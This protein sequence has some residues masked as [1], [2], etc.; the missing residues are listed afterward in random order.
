M[1]RI[2]GTAHRFCD[3]LTRR[4]F[5]QIGALGM[6]GLALPELLRAESASR[7]G[8]SQKSVIMV[9]LPGGPPHQDLFDLKLDA[10]SEI[11]GEMKPIATRVPGIQVCEVLPR[12]AACMD[13]VAVIRSIVGSDGGHDDFQCMTGRSMRKPPGGWPQLGAVVSKLAGPT[14]QDTPAFVG[15]ENRM[16]H[17]PYNSSTPGFLG[18]A[19]RSFLPNGEAKDD[20]VLTS[21]TADRLSNRRGLLDRLD[22]FRRDADASGAMDGLDAF[23]KQAYGIL[24]SSRLVEALDYR[25]EDP[26]V[27]ERYGKG[28]PKIRGDAAPRIN[29]QF[30]MARRLIEAGVRVV[31]VAYGFW[32]YHGNNFGL[33]RE[34]APMLDQAL[35]ALVEDLH[36]RGLDQDVS[37]VV[38]GEFGRTPQINK[39][40]GR[41]HWPRVSCAL[42]AGGG[43]RT[44]QVIGATDRMGGEA[45]DRPVTFA[46]VFAT[47]YHNLGFDLD[48]TTVP[49]LSGRPQY[50]VDAAAKPLAELV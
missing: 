50:L 27:I 11:R 33:L 2:D 23:Q 32:D 15:L 37:V 28:D 18:V 29:E 4:N 7:A 47:L 5:L 38:W 19:H 22:R 42:L 20:M 6:G 25:R 34:D 43:M 8:R 24:T 31:T 17:R 13:K 35:S 41:D 39:D 21:I 26:R 1:L 9:Y 30:I 16:Q 40:K 49:D 14:R 48:A 12:L 45:T 44:G 3:G 46:E 36:A 10:P